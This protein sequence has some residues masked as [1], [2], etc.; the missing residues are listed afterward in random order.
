MT[1][2]P[3]AHL[4]DNGNMAWVRT[5]QVPSYSY[6]DSHSQTNGAIQEINK[7]NDAALQIETALKDLKD[8]RQFWS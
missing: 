4:T 8:E 6:I 2:T 7:T 1:I 3:I 5:L